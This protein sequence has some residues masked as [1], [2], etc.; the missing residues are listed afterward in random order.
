MEERIQALR[1]AL[2]EAKRVAALTGAGISAESGVPTLPLGLL[3]LFPI[4]N[5]LPTVNLAASGDIL[6]E[7]WLPRGR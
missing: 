6:L 3:D 5:L 4:I 1:E 2:S 7:I